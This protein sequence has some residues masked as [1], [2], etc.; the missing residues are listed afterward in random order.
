MQPAAN[1]RKLLAFCWQLEQ[2]G[3]RFVIISFPQIEPLKCGLV[4]LGDI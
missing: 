1:K 3:M 2:S 4:F